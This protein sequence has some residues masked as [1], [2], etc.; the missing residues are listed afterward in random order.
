MISFVLH[1]GREKSLLRHH[2]WIFS[3]AVDKVLTDA[4][5]DAPVK[6]KK[7]IKSGTLCQVLSSELKFL[8]Y[9]HFSPYSQIMLRAISFKQEDRIDYDFIK[10]RIASAMARRGAL[11]IRGDHGIRLVSAE[12]DYMPGLIVDRFNNVISVAISS[13]GM[14]SC[15]NHIFRALH[16]LNPDCYLYERSD[17]KSR[18]KEN[19]PLRAGLVDPEDLSPAYNLKDKAGNGLKDSKQITSVKRIVTDADSASQSADAGAASTSEN[20]GERISL[21]EAIPDT[22]F[23][24]ERGLVEIPIDVKHGHKTGGYLD[25]RQSR[26]HTYELCKTFKALSEDGK[27]G[28]TVLNCFSY[29]GGFSLHALKGGAKAV[30][31]VDVSDNALNAARQGVV[32][33]HL[34]PGRCKFINKD[35]FEYLRQEVK[36]GTKFDIVILDPPKFAEN[37]SNLVSACRG[38]QDIN[39]LGMQLVR[40]GGRLLTFSC[41]GL[42]TED[43]FQKIIADAALEANVEAQLVTTLRQDID[44]VVS[45]PCPETFYL[46]GFEILIN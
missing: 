44:H 26:Y 32:H 42:M 25:Q 46:K 34:D 45:L 28:P 15:Y 20:L 29:T 19:L 30:F 27:T 14:E 11:K 37:K 36:K 22:L 4:R 21:D 12:G 6:D 43:L 38:Y 23:V 10:G 3:K 5:A 9:A 1:A 7:E 8:C 33:N 2:P 17:A 40:S 13:S 35:V 18:S 39:R 24:L 31:N 41:S 16:E